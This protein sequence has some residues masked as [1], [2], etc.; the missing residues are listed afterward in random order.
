MPAPPFRSHPVE[1]TSRR[2]I[3][4]QAPFWA[5][6]LVFPA[7]ACAQTVI[8]AG[9]FIDIPKLRL[10][11]MTTTIVTAG[12]SRKGL[13][14]A[15]YVLD[16]N[17]DAAWVTSHPRSAAISAD[18]RGFR[19]DRTGGDVK[20]YGAIGDGV[21]DDT[22]AINEALSGG[23]TVTLSGPSNFLVTDRLLMPVSRT[24]LS[25]EASVTL[26]IS[27]WRYRGGQ[28][29]FGNSIHI[30]G[31]D[32]EVLGAGPTS[33]L[34]ND[35]S[36]AN[37]IG[38]LHCGGGRVTGLTLRGDKHHVSAIKDDTFQ[39]AISIIND[40]A[41]NDEGRRSR[42]VVEDC[43]ISDWTQYGI[44]LYGALVRDVI[45]RRNAIAN[46]GR[47]DDRESVGAGIA[48]TRGIGSL[49]IE[50]NSID[51]NKGCGVF[52]SSAGVVIEGIAIIDNRIRN[53][54]QEGVCC[55]EEKQF[56]GINAIGMRTITIV[57]NRIEG[58]RRG[59]IR[60]G[61]YDGVGTI[62]DMTID[63]NL[64]AN[65]YGSGILL[66]S[67][68]DPS[69][70]IDIT[71]RNNRFIANLEYGIAIGLNQLR[72]RHAGNRFDRNGQ[73]ESIDYRDGAAHPLAER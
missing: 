41:S 1:T 30:T 39:S 36:D 8:D 37:G 46:I 15:R 11:E 48:V 45:I 67:N 56:G 23:G 59:G 9:L 51:D 64:I 43:T 6:I 18:G 29:P 55:S 24:R 14:G 54:G 26:L 40:P 73:G 21:A 61:T 65:N 13:G 10:P 19:L 62:I 34:Q 25:F 27:A 3:L 44:N 66:Q 53:N 17:V 38:F 5:T 32:C 28:V 60:A 52:I 31:D 35:H 22:A 50:G 4:R 20:R 58:N 71:V 16:P 49:R 68:T 47:I 33:V 7:T 57:G 70:S 63:N 72:L 12:W 69:R 2:A 42:T